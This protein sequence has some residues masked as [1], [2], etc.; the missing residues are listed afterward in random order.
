[1]C[2]LMALR[3]TLALHLGACSIHVLYNYK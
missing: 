1:V 3:Q 2:Y